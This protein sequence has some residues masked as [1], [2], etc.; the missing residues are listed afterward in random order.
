MDGFEPF[1]TF[2]ETKVDPLQEEQVF[3]IVRQSLN[4]LNHNFQCNCPLK[5]FNKEAEMS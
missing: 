4:A 1:Y 3:L 2:W 5:I